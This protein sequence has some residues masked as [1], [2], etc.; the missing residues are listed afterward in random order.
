MRKLHN[1]LATAKETTYKN[2][3]LLLHFNTLDGSYIYFIVDDI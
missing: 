1:V 3:L 2:S